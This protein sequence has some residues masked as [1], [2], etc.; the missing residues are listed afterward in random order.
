M[1]ADDQ[2]EAKKRHDGRSGTAP[3]ELVDADQRSDDPGQQRIDE[4]AQDRDRNGY[5]FKS[6]EQSEHDAGEQHA[7]TE[8]DPALARRVRNRRW[9]QPQPADHEDDAEHAAEGGQRE[10]VHAGDERKLAEHV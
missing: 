6:L 1:R 5:E 2:S 4:I 8:R 7:D 9:L 3:T 10:H